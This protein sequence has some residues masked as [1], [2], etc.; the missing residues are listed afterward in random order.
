[1]EHGL[2]KMLKQ[3]ASSLL[4]TREAY[5]VKRRSFPNSFGCFTLHLSRTMYEEDGIGA[6]SYRSHEIGTE[7]K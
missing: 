1:Q 6:P 2:S 5:L 7:R 4:D 3:F